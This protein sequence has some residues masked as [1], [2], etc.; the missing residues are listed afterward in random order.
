[1]KRLCTEEEVEYFFAEYEDTFLEADKSLDACEDGTHRGWPLIEI[2]EILDKGFSEGSQSGGMGVSRFASLSE[3]DLLQT[4]GIQADDGHIRGWHY[5]VHDYGKVCRDSINLIRDR[6]KFES[7]SDNFPY[8]SG[9]SPDGY[10][11]CKL[12]WEQLVGVASIV[13]NL[14]TPE[15]NEMRRGIL[16]ADEVG[17]GKTGTILGLLALYM[18]LFHNSDKGFSSSPILSKYPEAP[19]SLSHLCSGG[20]KSFGARLKEEDPAVPDRPILIICPVTLISQWESE[21]SRFFPP[22]SVDVFLYTG[23]YSS[24]SDFFTSGAYT[25]SKHAPHRRIIIASHPVC[26]LKLDN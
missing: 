5:H 19:L 20:M 16:L 3:A 17:I 7:K 11:P 6:N 9:P 4:L 15:E 26:C 2:G 24:H 10:S 13:H 18:N 14:C 23:G 21:I 1:M 8:F 25:L 22:G 12:R